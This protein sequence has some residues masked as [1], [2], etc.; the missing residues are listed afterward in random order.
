MYN[1][2]IVHKRFDQII[3]IVF[4]EQEINMEKSKILF[5]RIKKICKHLKEFIGKPIS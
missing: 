5:A 4:A 1:A 2:K 3:K